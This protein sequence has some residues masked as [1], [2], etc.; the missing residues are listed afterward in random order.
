MARNTKGRL[1]KRGENY[2]L[3]YSVNGKIFRH[4][5]R[6]EDGSPARTIRAAEEI[7]NKILA[8]L[9][10]KSD[11]KREEGV[12]AALATAERKAAIAEDE[13]NPPLRIK[14]AWQAY[15]DNQDRP[16][17]GERT[18]ADYAGYFNQ[19][20]TWQETHCSGAV[21]MRDIT[22]ESAAGYCS[23]MKKSGLSANT[24]NKRLF[25]MKLIYRVLRKAI[26]AP[27]NPF[28]NIKPQKLKQTPRRELTIDELNLILSNAE[29][30]L[31]LLLGLGT[32]TGLRLGDCC[33]LQWGEID[34]A[35]H[36]IRRVPNKTASRSGKP[37]L[38]GIP[39]ILYDR[40]AE[41]PR[42]ARKGWLFPE[43]AA[44]YLDLSKRPVIT[45]KIQE[46]FERCG[47]QTHKPGTGQD[48][49]ARAVVEVGFHSL[50]HTYVSL[51]A[52]RGV[53][54]AVIQGNVGHG[55]A[56]MTR[57]YLHVSEDT[58]RQ[59][60]ET[61]SL[62]PPPDTEPERERLIELARTADIK[63]IRGLLRFAEAKNLL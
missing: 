55:N 4:V 15:A 32:F 22:P 17:S 21:F 59:M 23:W 14:D 5:L 53:P 29:G 48:T 52:E 42:T 25:F 7:K 16:D 37:V 27:E 54:L 18:L 19:F 60:A 13:A 61:L 44:K 6:D 45:R 47:I 3:Q 26:R 38:I 35:R 33:T 30:E 62:A 1:Y 11:V 49:G 12:L 28:E 41:T 10:T 50:R 39:Q 20:K 9:F 36:V 51:C 46:Y 8:P 24:F 58:A 40:L 56:A 2:Y 63:K 57:H 31:A 43:L 34:L